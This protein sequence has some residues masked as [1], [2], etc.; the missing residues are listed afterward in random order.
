MSVEAVFWAV[1][2]LALL[3]IAA[4]I[5]R[6]RT[7]IFRRYFVPSSLIAGGLGLLLGPQVLGAGIPGLR[8]HLIAAFGPEPILVLTLVLTLFWILFGLLV[9]GKEAREN[10]RAEGEAGRPKS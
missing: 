1:L 5:V 3:I 4:R 2:L 6:Q 8:S 9:F 10:R 7:R